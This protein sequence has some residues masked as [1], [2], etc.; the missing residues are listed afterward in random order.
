LHD[1]QSPLFARD[2][3]VGVASVIA[4]F[5]VGVIARIMVCWG[6]GRTRPVGLDCCVTV[7]VFVITRVIRGI[8]RTR[9]V[10]REVGVGVGHEH[11]LSCMA[12]K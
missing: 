4:G 11:E 10:G 9:A 5:G 7:G 1:A 6:M 12:L 2:V 3:G 8:S